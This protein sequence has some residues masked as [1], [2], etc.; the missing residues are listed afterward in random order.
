MAARD[1]ESDFSLLDLDLTFAEEDSDLDLDMEPMDSDL[2]LDL[3]PLDLD[4]DSDLNYLDLT[5]SLAIKFSMSASNCSFAFCFA[6]LIAFNN[7]NT[8]KSLVAIRLE[9][10]WTE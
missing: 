1:V 3:G 5:T 7:K 8:G 6:R 2:A 10:S 9:L 4:L